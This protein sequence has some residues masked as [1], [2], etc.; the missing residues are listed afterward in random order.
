MDSMI[1]ES[2]EPVATEAAYAW[3]T[4]RG[5]EAIMVLLLIA[6]TLA[7]Y[8]PATRNG[9]INYDDNS[10]ITLNPHVQ[11]GLTLQNIRWA[12]T[13]FD[14]SNWHPLTW[15]S[16]MLDCQ[17]FGLNPAGHHFV[18]ILLHAF[19][20]ALVFW[21]LLRATGA[22]WRSFWVAALFAVHPLNV[23]S[24]AWVA[25]R[26]NVLS[27]L[28][29]LLTIAAYG[30]YLQQR[31]WKRYGLLLLLFALSLMA[32]PMLVTLP[33]ALLLL[34]FWPLERIRSF[35]EWRKAG[36]L[37]LEKTPLLALSF[38]SSV[39]TMEAQRS[40]MSALVWKDPGWPR[41]FKYWNAI[42]SYPQYLRKMIWPS[43]LAIFYP[44][45]SIGLWQ[46]LLSALALCIVTV[47]VFRYAKRGYLT[48]GWLWYLG[49]L[50][51]VIGV[52]SVG[53]QAMADRY[54]Y[55]PLLGIFVLLVWSAADLAENFFS[56][57]L[58]LV[59]GLLLAGI[60]ALRVVTHNQLP[61][62]HD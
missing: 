12:F 46:V 17:L 20:V 36:F 57:M 27:T 29:G 28:F 61:Y 4:R 50:I 32:K 35:A 39:V 47:L 7:L 15:I 49:M 59:C 48:V 40:S 25:E 30:W 62:W 60:I 24:V 6:G 22:Q 51:P 11:A 18:S 34:D 38:A 37:L 54:A 5:Q 45:H 41:F 42:Y 58:P 9:F 19:N 21:L 10:Y 44:L 16:H 55:V 56:R 31:N 43:K 26:K 52:V 8:N 13:T 1:T 2:A 14:V 53:R 23:E 33:L 3:R